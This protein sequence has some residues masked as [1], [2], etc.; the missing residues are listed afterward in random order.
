VPAE[1]KNR[2]VLIKLLKMGNAKMQR[3]KIYK[4]SEE[5]NG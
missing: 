3:K 4:I 2:G 1:E 5:E